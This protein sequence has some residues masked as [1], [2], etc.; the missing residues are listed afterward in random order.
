MVGSIGS[1]K[2]QSWRDTRCLRSRWLCWLFGVPDRQDTRSE[3]RW[4]CWDGRKV[5]MA[6][7]GH[8]DRRSP[9]L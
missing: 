5:Q 6:Q 8:Q 9:E 7:R 2:D 1:R 3:G 4:N